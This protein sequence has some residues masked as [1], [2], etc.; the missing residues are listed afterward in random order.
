MLAFSTN[1]FKIHTTFYKTFNIFLIWM[2]L[3]NS[4]PR[5]YTRNAMQVTTLTCP[6]TLLVIWQGN[7]MSRLSNCTSDLTTT[8]QQT[9]S[10]LPDGMSSLQVLRVS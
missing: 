10:N 5:Q 8:I 9:G 3:S 4:F 7:T 6:I 1:S 2:R